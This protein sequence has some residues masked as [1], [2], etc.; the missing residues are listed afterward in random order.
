MNV[1][2][3]KLVSGE[4][5][6]AEFEESGDKITLT[7]PVQISVIPSRTDAIPT[8]GFLPFPVHT[9]QSKNTVL[10]LNKNH[11]IFECEAG[12]EFLQQYNSIFGSGIITP[13]KNILFN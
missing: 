11:I 12:E 2:C 7:N 8:F 9:G 10:T 4:D 13:S 5:I 6:M 3:F 1:K